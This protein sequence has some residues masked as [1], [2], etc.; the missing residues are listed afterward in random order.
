[1]DGQGRAVTDQ[2]SQ[3]KGKTPPSRVPMPW[4]RRLTLRRLRREAETLI[5][6]AVKKE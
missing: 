5:H 2:A 3:E 4:N 1:M 6:G